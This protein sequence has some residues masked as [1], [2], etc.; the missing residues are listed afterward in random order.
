MSRKIKFRAFDA[1]HKVWIYFNILKNGL[2]DVPTD[3]IINVNTLMQY[4]G[5][6]DWTGIEIYE[7]DIVESSQIHGYKWVIEYRSDKEFVGFVPC[8]IGKKENAL[9]RFVDWSTLVPIGNIYQNPELLN[10]S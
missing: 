8:E 1:Y 3:K 4:T 6:K 10:G 2:W 9:S 7:G 5:R